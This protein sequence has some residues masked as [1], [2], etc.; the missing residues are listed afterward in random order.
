MAGIAVVCL[1]GKALG[2]KSSMLQAARVLGREMIYEN[3][4]IMEHFYRAHRSEKPD[5]SNVLNGWVVLNQKYVGQILRSRFFDVVEH[6]KVIETYARESG[7]D[8]SELATLLDYAPLSQNGQA[9]SDVRR[10]VAVRI[11]ERSAQAVQAFEMAAASLLDKTLVPNTSFDICR[12]VF[13]PLTVKMLAALSGIPEETLGANFPAPV[14]AIQ[15]FGVRQP[16]S[17]KRLAQMNAHVANIGR[18]QRDAGESEAISLTTAVLG[19]EPLH[20]SLVISFVNQ[21]L[22]NAGKSLGEIEFPDQL[23]SSDLPFVERVAMEDCVIDDLQ[24]DKGSKWYLY[25]G[26]FENERRETFFGAGKHLCLGKPL[27]E[28]VWK[29][30]TSALRRHGV[31]VDILEVS[32]RDFD[33]VFSFPSKVQVSVRSG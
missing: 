25:L 30:L 26:S 1:V 9:H 3:T 33:Y 7:L 6:K 10:K 5:W 27:S 8:L 12:Q 15:V 18:C 22:K 21:V 31:I 23:P 13:N 14:S 28:K 4:S 11:Q 20:G 24:I 32:F 29:V 16:I 2:L 17:S 19:A